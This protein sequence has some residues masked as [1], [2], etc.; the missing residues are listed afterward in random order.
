MI[1]Q[2]SSSYMSPMKVISNQPTFLSEEFEVGPG[3]IAVKTLLD[4]DFPKGHIGVK[5]FD[6]E[7]VDEDG[8][9][10]P[11]YEA[12][13]HHWF[14]VKYIENITLSHYIKQSHDLRK[15]YRI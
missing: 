9:S 4:I 12:Y 15:W 10:V 2:L 7:V 3:K 5:S 8:K 14:V 13:L 6:V 1:S 11:L